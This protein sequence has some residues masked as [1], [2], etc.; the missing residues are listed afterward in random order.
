MAHFAEIVNGVVQR[1][2]VVHDNELLVNDVKTP[3]KGVEFC[4][5]LLG[6]DWVYIPPQPH[7]S[8]TLDENFDWQPPTPMPTD[9][10]RYAWF[11]PN[12][13]WIEIVEP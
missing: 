10:K 6:G 7:L 8:W 5:N 13:Q 1:T 12:K 2:I 9:G 11:E 4:Q 3:S